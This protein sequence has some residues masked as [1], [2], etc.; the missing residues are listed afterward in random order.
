VFILGSQS[1]SL[2]AIAL[3]ARERSRI[4]S[5]AQTV[6]LLICLLIFKAP[7]RA[8]SESSGANLQTALSNHVSQARFARAVWGI[9][10]VDLKTEKTLI[11]INSGKLLKPASLA[12]IFT[13]ATALEELGPDYRIVTSLLSKAAPRAGKIDGPLY[14]YGRGDPSMDSR[15][16][17]NSATLRALAARLKENG[18]KRVTGPLVID[19]SFFDAIPYGTGW[20]WDDTHYGYGAKVS[21]LNFR[22]NVVEL[23]VTPAREGNLRCHIRP[24]DQHFPYNIE[25]FTRTASLP[26]GLEQLRAITGADHV[27]TIYGGLSLGTDAK[28]I[29][30]PIESVQQTVGQQMLAV[31]NEGGILAKEIRF[32]D[33]SPRAPEAERV[34]NLYELAAVQSPPI[35]DLVRPILTSS[36]NLYS[37]AL[38]L[39]LGKKTQLDDSSTIE[40]AG[41]HRVRQ[42]MAKFG[43]DENEL[44]LD[45]GTGLSR[46]ALATPNAV[47]AALIGMRGNKTFSTALAAPG[48]GTMRT[49]LSG[50]TGKVR[51]K[52]GSLKTVSTLA[53][54]ATPSEGHELAFAIFLNNYVPADKSP[55][56]AEE[57]DRVL[58]IMLS[59]P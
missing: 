5:G 39:H 11:D 32:T 14:L 27:L 13:A 8:Q 29:K 35:S 43:I 34:E 20:T 17:T 44:L 19:S 58:Q 53:G 4:A 7:S 25:N 48:E 18:V 45:E 55:S 2:C 42:A 37:Q 59:T 16:L 12:K 26:N 56:A 21:A 46:S 28:I 24:L 47:T 22:E 57:V 15:I 50:L 31:L 36:Q 9:K 23:E 54:Y 10:V 30:I 6:A 3:V 51:V 33:R 38:F 1:K 49:R 41:I 52:S 40:E